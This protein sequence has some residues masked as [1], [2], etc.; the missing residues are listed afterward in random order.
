MMSQRKSLAR[1]FGEVV[2]GLRIGVAG[3]R[4]KI[5]VSHIDISWLMLQNASA[6]KL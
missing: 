2:G 4:E 6:T 1:W 5:Y 3:V